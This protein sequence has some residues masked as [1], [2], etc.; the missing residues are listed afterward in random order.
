ML[1]H[2]E[3]GFITKLRLRTRLG[4]ISADTGG[5]ELLFGSEN[6]SGERPFA[7]LSVGDSVRFVRGVDTDEVGPPLATIVQY[8]ER[9]P[10][11]FADLE[12]PNNPKAR[13]KKPTW[14]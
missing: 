8:A 4:F 3:L 9:K 11:K 7:R 14:R 13:R 10:K 6:V 12:L 5:P 2:A 1:Q